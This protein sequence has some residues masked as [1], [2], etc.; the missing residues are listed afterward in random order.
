MA[1]GGWKRLW[2]RHWELHGVEQSCRSLWVCAQEMVLQGLTER[3]M[4]DVRSLCH[5]GTPS[6]YHPHH[7]TILPLHCATAA[8]TTSG[9]KGCL[10]MQSANR[11]TKWA[12]HLKASAH[13]LRARSHH[14]KRRGSPF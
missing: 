7:Q 8:R 3:W 1:G 2:R 10:V 6:S 12:H 14:F 13:P 11:C 4:I 9:R 5:S